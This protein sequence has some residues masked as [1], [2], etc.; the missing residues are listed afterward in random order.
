M[1]Q[2]HEQSAI[3]SDSSVAIPPPSAPTFGCRFE[4]DRFY[5]SAALSAATGISTGALAVMRHRG[6]GPKFTRLGRNIFYRGAHII[7]H[8]DAGAARNTAELAVKMGNRQL[9]GEA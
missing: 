5:S 4:V 3:N 1:P 9:A 7:E 6:N 8:L 2:A